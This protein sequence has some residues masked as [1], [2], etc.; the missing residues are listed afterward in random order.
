MKN[1]R[2]SKMKSRN[3]LLVVPPVE[4][5]SKF[6]QESDIV[7]NSI[8]EKIISLTLSS[9]LRN[10]IDNELPL[11]CF[12]YIEEFLTN[13]LKIEFLP[14]DSDDAQNNKN[15]NELSILSNKF[16]PHNSSFQE[17]NQNNNNSYIIDK[18]KDFNVNNSSFNIDQF[19]YNNSINGE[20]DWD[21]TEEPKSNRYDSYSTTMVKLKEIKKEEA[22]PVQIKHRKNKKRL[23]T[24]QLEAVKEEESMSKSNEYDE[25]EKEDENE[26]NKE[27]E[28]E[29][30]N[31]KNNKN[32]E[33]K[34]NR[35]N[36]LK[37]KYGNQ[38]VKRIS[39]IAQNQNNQQ[40]K[41]RNDID[42]NQFPCQ[43]IEVDE[44]YN[45]E[46]KNTEIDYNKL[47]KDLID[48]EEAK[49][50]EELNKNKK[51]PKTFDIKQ[52]IG[53]NPA[54]KQYYG[55]NIT[56]DPNGQIVLIKAIKLNKLKQEFKYPRTVLRNIKQPKK[57]VKK[58]KKE[59]KDEKKEEKDENIIRKDDQINENEKE[60]NKITEQ[61]NG[62][63]LND[64]K[65]L[66]KISSKRINL[67][68]LQIKTENVELKKIKKEPVFPS[69]SNFDL[70]NME[71]GVSIKEDEKFKTGGKDFYKKFN[72]YSR[73]IYNEKLKE[74][75]TANSFLNTKTQILNDESNRFKTETNFDNT[76]AGFNMTG[77]QENFN[78]K[79]NS[80]YLMT[81]TNNFGNYNYISNIINSNN[82]TNI[83]TKTATTGMNQ[84]NLL[85]PSIKL[86][87]ISSLI[88]SL[89]RLNLITEREEKLGKNN[90]NIFREQHKNKLKNLFLNK[91]TEMDE[92]TKE[93]LKTGEL[94]NRE[95]Y[96]SQGKNMY[97]SR[98]NPEKP[99]ML[100]LTRE[101]GY[102]N[103]PYRNRSKMNSSSINPIL[104][105]VAF[106]KQ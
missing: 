96:K 71:I 102:K 79:D 42:I 15:P 85:N 89:D 19:Y 75:M 7:A 35:K 76:Y 38:I 28:D 56:V 49:L 60:L 20:N 64:K 18:S 21:I 81:S 51:K 39:L 9:A 26:N 86:S 5:K 77:N 62:V 32:N 59:E 22:E 24:N 54:N 40:K 63:N 25:D 48:R 92:F 43:D 83:M 61:L 33:D 44:Y 57:I 88:G 101:I 95:G 73:E 80:K 93:I 74:S 46:E 31:E 52:I 4:I 94:S 66:P 50:K 1:K 27:N 84:S 67:Q 13:K 104:S 91:Y 10:K 6:S 23:K 87:N 14:H 45:Y 2:K 103:K 65:I 58:E 55:K 82:N 3:S 99:S 53:E 105:T 100:E 8:I 69:G 70:I 90:S 47:R 17:D 37:K 98:K 106:F 41:K 16:M 78:Q 72:K 12:S 68:N 34:E 11:K 36:E 29:N 30:E 97:M